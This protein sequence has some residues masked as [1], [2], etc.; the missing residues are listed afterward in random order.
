MKNHPF[1]EAR[2]PVVASPATEPLMR[3]YAEL[4]SGRHNARICNVPAT[5]GNSHSASETI[6]SFA[7]EG[8]I[9]LIVSEWLA[10]TYRLQ[11]LLRL[12]QELKVPVVCVR[13][14]GQT[15]ARRIVVATA[16]GPNVLEQMWIARE[17]A[18]AHGIPVS[19]IN[20]RPEKPCSQPTGWNNDPSDEVTLERLSCR[21]L[22]IHAD[23]ETRW[24]ADFATCALGHLRPDDLLIM[25]APSPLRLQADFK[26]SIPDAVAKGFP[27]SIILLSSP[28][29]VSVSLRRLLWGELI[30]PRMKPSNKEEALDVL[31]E[32]LIRHNQI[33]RSSKSEILDQALRREQRMSTAVDCET[34]FPHV[35]LRGFFGVAASMGIVPDGVAF[36]SEDGQPT[37]FIALFITPDGLY[38]DYLAALAKLAKRMIDHKVREALLSCETPSQARDILDPRQ[39]DIVVPNLVLAQ[40]VRG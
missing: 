12:G 2:V 27:G 5:T 20:W 34:A 17:I 35:M 26:D 10:D 24:G 8:R 14:T 1:Y 15:P 11:D 22:G 9:G 39:G 40:K 4:L 18:Q 37:R 28:P 25:G 16:G 3:W 38:D 36:G 31:V 19:L 6:R 7:M 33:P 30:T 21:L 32:N 23:F 13:Q 29:T